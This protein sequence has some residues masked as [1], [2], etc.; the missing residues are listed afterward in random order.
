M[1][2][3]RNMI[4]SM[5]TG[6]TL[7]GVAVGLPLYALHSAN[8]RA[9]RLEVANLELKTAYMTLQQEYGT[10]RDTVQ[11]EAKEARAA[12]DREQK[13]LQEETRKAKERANAEIDH[14]KRRVGALSDE[15]RDRAQRP[16]EA[17]EH[18]ADNAGHR[19][20]AAAMCTGA[21]L[22]REDAQFLVGEAAAAEQLR[23]AARQCFARLN[24]ASTSS[25]GMKLHAGSFFSTESN[26]SFS[27][28][29]K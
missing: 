6:L 27:D 18:G 22:Y 2:T 25:Q 21:Q 26:I 23:S 4:L 17:A 29:Q 1:S 3:A 10:Y 11:R 28:K 7:A 16:A 19:A 12:A 20:D 13:R 5:A 8:Q 14:L 15:L 9:D 24:A